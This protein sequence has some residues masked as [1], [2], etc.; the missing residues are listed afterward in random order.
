MILFLFILNFLF[1]CVI[2]FL[3]CIALKL[4]NINKESKAIIELYQNNLD[5]LLNL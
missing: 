3:F 5:F 2:I 4:Y 1:V